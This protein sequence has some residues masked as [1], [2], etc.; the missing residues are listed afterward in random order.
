MLFCIPKEEE[1][2]EKHGSSSPQ[3]PIRNMVFETKYETRDKKSDK[4]LS[5][6]NRCF[7]DRQLNQRNTASVE[8]GSDNSSWSCFSDEEYIV[9]CFRKDGAFDVVKDDIDSKPEESTE[10]SRSSRPVNRKVNY[11]YALQFISF[12]LLVFP[13]CLTNLTIWWGTA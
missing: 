13:P 2:A 12:F 3:L 10:S 1:D 9:F 11:I 5:R 8:N 4:R 7:K 6:G